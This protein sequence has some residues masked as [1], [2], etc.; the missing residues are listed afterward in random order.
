MEPR[1]RERERG[2]ESGREGGEGEGGRGGRGVCAC[3]FGSVSRLFGPWTTKSNTRNRNFSTVGT[4][5][6]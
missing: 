6:A 5:H 2:R 3:V 1:E 4:M